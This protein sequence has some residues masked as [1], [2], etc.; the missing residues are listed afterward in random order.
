MHAFTVVV[1]HFVDAGGLSREISSLRT[2][3]GAGG[4]GTIVVSTAEVAAMQKRI[5]ALEA[6]ITQLQ[7]AA[8]IVPAVA[9]AVA[10][11][12]GHGGHGHH[13]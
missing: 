13:K 1:L 9:A 3:A 2:G 5:Q 7:A 8:G 6:A 10:G 12:G 4:A 11:H